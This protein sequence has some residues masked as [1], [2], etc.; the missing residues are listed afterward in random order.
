MTRRT[1]GQI[2]AGA[3]ASLGVIGTAVASVFTR[4]HGK[5]WLIGP[6]DDW[7]ARAGPD[8]RIV[9][10]V[11]VQEGGTLNVPQGVAIDTVTMYG[12]EVKTLADPDTWRN[13][14]AGVMADIQAA[15]DRALK[16][17]GYPRLMS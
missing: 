16:D 7:P 4:R 1:F 11:T 15:K 9:L 5:T 13:D 17:T 12:G 3:T 6:D 10:N 2:V 8:D 14:A